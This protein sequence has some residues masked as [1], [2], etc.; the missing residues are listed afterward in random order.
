MSPALAQDVG[1][2]TTA[3]PDAP[4]LALT[5]FARGTLSLLTVWPSLR[6]AI[7]NDWRG[8][9]P[10]QETGNEKRLRLCSELVDAFFTA[11]EPAGELSFNFFFFCFFIFAVIMLE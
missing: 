9:H 10:G 1:G 4:P 2:S 3:D 6:L 8:A 11:T 7:E 5:L